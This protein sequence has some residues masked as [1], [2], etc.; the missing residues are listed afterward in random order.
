MAKGKEIFRDSMEKVNTD[1]PSTSKVHKYD[2]VVVED[3]KTDSDEDDVLI[4]TT[5]PRFV[6]EQVYEET[7]Q[8]KKVM[9]E[10]GPHYLQS[11]LVVYLNFKCTDEVV[12]PNQVFVTTGNGDKVHPEINKIVEEDNKAATKEGL[13]SNQS[14]VEN[15]LNKKSTTFQ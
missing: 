4:A 1:Q 2:H 5:I 15:T 6:A 14:R 12:L 8:F 11:N 10:K 9:K 3:Y 13:F 7:K